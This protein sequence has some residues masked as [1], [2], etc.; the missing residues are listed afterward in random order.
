MGPKPHPTVTPTGPG[1][2]PKPAG[3]VKDSPVSQGCQGVPVG[4]GGHCHPADTRKGQG[5]ARGN[6]Q[7][8]VLLQPSPFPRWIFH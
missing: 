3:R 4:Q 7:P 5:A 6:P 2:N 8:Y 1:V